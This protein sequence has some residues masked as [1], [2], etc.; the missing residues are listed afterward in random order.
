MTGGPL[1]PRQLEVLQWI[2]DG[3]PDGVTAEPTYKT[4]AAALKSRH[5]ATVSKRGGWHA[6][7]TDAGRYYL[8]HGEYPGPTG[9]RVAATTGLKPPVA[10]SNVPA[11]RAA[12]ASEPSRDGALPHADAGELQPRELSAAHPVPV[13]VQLRALHPAVAALRDDTRRFDLTSLVRNRALRILQGIAGAAEHEGYRVRE[14][15]HTG[16]PGSYQHWDSKDHVVIETGETSVEV[17][18][19]QE[20][21]RT[22]HDPTPRELDRQKRWGEGWPKYDHT[23]NDRLRVEINSRWD[24]RRRSWSDGVRAQVEEKLPELFAEVAFRHAEAMQRR[25]K[26]DAVEA[27]RERQRRIAV[28]RAKVLLRESHRAHVLA[29]QTA[30]WRRAGEERAYVDSMATAIEAISDPVEHEAA[31][32][33]LVWARRHAEELDPL[34]DALRMP[35]DPE[36]TLEALRPFLGG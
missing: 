4:S 34:N 2:A 17:R 21:D 26:A 8:A 12:P 32:E 19:F 1:N 15:R 14:V 29:E 27:E 7:L 30:N 9:K 31:T 20:T 22:P 25:L 23:P 24:G 18:V 16:H 3:C 11:R 33:W 36:P 28:E 5:L 35:N 6:A 13:P 10:S